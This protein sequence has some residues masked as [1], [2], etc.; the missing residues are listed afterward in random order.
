MRAS[1]NNQARVHNGYHYPRSYTTAFRSRIN[2]PRFV[3]DH[4][5]AIK[6]DFTKLYAIARNSQVSAKQFRRFCDEIGARLKPARAG[7]RS[8]FN[9]SLIE[10]VFEVEELAFDAAQLRI[11]A[12]RDL[13]HCGVQVHLGHQVIDIGQSQ[14]SRGLRVNGVVPGHPAERFTLSGRYVFN[15]TYSGLNQLGG[16]FPGTSAGLK[17]EIAELAFVE[18]P[19]ALTNL[20]V[21]VMDGPFFS[22]LPFPGRGLHSLSHVRYTPHVH[23][24]DRTGLDP[25]ARLRSESKETRVDRMLRDACRYLPIMGNAR[26]VDSIFEVKTILAKN[27][28]DDGRPIL[29]ER[30]SAL[31][32]CYSILGGKIDNIYDIFEKLDAEPL[33][34]D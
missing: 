27:E 31:A 11:S 9:P 20:A 30:H 8:M 24:L 2:L 13:T 4:P 19:A 26:Y 5:S 14:D 28:A 16:A 12:H 22:A 18:M 25:Y 21:T 6:Q 23:W 15:C 34:L 1:S 29:F 10:D 7:F 3:H 17:Q 32:G 33:R